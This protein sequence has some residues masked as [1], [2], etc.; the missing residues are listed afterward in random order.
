MADWYNNAPGR[1]DQIA[2]TTSSWNFVE[3]HADP[4]SGEHLLRVGAARIGQ[5]GG[6]GDAADGQQRRRERR[7][8][9]A[10]LRDRGRVGYPD[11]RRVVVGRGHDGERDARRGA[12][13]RT[14]LIA[15]QGLA[16][17]P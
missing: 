14:P 12:L 6:V 8:R 3:Q 11:E 2:T 7:Q 15:A 4:A 10:H 1:G 16:I 5:D 17:A 9:D 13:R